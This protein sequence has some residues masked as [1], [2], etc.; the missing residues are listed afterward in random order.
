MKTALFTILF[1]TCLAAQAPADP[2]ALVR[3]IRS[4]LQ[5][6]SKLYADAQ[7]AVTVLGMNSISGPSES[8]LIEMH[9]SFATIEELDTALNAVTPPNNMP[10]LASDDVLAPSR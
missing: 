7:A 4:P 10:V 2:P 5:P 8:W 1:A 6:Y 9:D 3:V